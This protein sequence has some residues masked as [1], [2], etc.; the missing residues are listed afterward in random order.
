VKY[1][2]LIVSVVLSLIY[3][4]GH[5]PPSQGFNLW[6]TSFVIPVALVVNHGLLI[7][8]LLLRK[9]SA[10]FYLIALVVGIPYLTSTIGIKHLLRN[11]NDE[12]EKLSLLSYNMGFY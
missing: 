5:I 1:F 12:T 10:F 7:A 8:F 4:S 9:K 2:N 11:R 3:I 6:I